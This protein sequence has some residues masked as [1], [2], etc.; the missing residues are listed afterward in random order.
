VQGVVR[1][2]PREK[3]KK[4]VGFARAQ[5]ITDRLVSGFDV[6]LVQYDL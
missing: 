4:A 6:S 2:L 1:D 5:R 3:K